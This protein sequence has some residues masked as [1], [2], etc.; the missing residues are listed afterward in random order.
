MELIKMNKKYYIIYEY[1]KENNDITNK[2]EFENRN[3]LANWLKVRVDNLSKSMTKSMDNLPRLIQDK[4]FI[5][6]DKED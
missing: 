5:M 2:A 4:Y 3:D 6:I 1:N